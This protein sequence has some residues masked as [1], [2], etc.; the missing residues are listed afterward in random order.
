MS[1]IRHFVTCL[2]HGLAVA[3]VTT[4]G[5]TA[6]PPAAAQSSNSIDSVEGLPTFVM[7]PSGPFSPNEI[8]IPNA[9]AIA[10]WVRSGHSDASSEA[11]THWDEEGSIPPVCAT[12]HSGA[13]FRAFHGLDGSAPGLPEQ[14]VPTGGVVDCETCHNRN[15]GAVEQITLSSGVDH[16]VI[17]GEAACVTCHQGRAAGSSV[18]KAVDELPEDSPNEDLGFVNPHYAL[19][20]A[21]SLGGYGGLG[22]QYPGKTYTGRFLHAKPVSTCLS[23]HD[24]HSLEVTQDT[25][26]MCHQTGDPA[27]IRISRQSYDGSGNTSKGI[28]SD[29][30][31]NSELLMS[32]ISDYA[33]EVAGTPIVYDGGHYPYFFADANGDGLADERDGS[34]IKYASWTP[35]LLKAAYNWKFVNADHGIHVHNP[36]YALE[37]IYDSAEDLAG[38]LDTDFASLNL[39]R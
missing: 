35:R 6:A 2:F 25:C 7:P 33:A 19:A 29:I 31:A 12:C 14:P 4:I 15:L 5:L 30:E 9:R 34:R 21:S 1:R 27:E 38:Q 23:C 8:T 16:P 3:A 22:Y 36:H 32:L 37:L 13:G 10:A 28:R 17:V 18:T 39:L 11:F 24:P 26:L 20:A